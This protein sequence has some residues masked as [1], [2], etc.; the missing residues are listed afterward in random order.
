MNSLYELRGMFDSDP[1]S[2]R[3]ISDRAL[4]ENMGVVNMVECVVPLIDAIKERIATTN[5]DP[6]YENGS[7]SAY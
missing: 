1:E 3:L 6:A 5:P 4:S 2:L 7:S